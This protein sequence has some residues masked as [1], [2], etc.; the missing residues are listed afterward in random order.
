MV[1]GF[2]MIHE[3]TLR[4]DPDYQAIRP[5]CS[6]VQHISQVKEQNMTSMLFCPTYVTG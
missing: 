5:R 3:Y 6:S 4:R 2:E 1:L